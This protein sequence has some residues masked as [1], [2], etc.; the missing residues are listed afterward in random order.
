MNSPSQHIRRRSYT[1]G[2]RQ[3]FNAR[4]IQE[5]AEN[6]QPVFSLII[7]RRGCRGGKKMEKQS[8]SY[9]AVKSAHGV[10]EGRRAR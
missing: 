10:T 7:Q 5:L 4:Q 2:T 8:P 1:I 9:V 3:T 6:N